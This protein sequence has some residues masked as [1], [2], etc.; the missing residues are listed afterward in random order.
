MKKMAFSFMPSCVLLLY[1]VT[2][3]WVGGVGVGYKKSIFP[4]RENTN[5]IASRCQCLRLISADIKFFPELRSQ[6]NLDHSS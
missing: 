1:F 4:T 6:A 3:M 2:L 5:T